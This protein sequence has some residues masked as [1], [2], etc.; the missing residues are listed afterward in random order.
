MTAPVD[1]RFTAVPS[2]RFRARFGPLG[3]EAAHSEM[4]LCIVAT[5]AVLLA[6]LLYALSLR[7]DCYFVKYGTVPRDGMYLGR[8]MLATNDAVSELCQE[9]KGHPRLMVSLQDDAWFGRFRAE[10]VAESDCGIWEDWVEHE[11]EVAAVVEAAFG[12][13]DEAQ[14]IAAV[15]ATRDDT[16]S[17]VA[18]IPPAQSGQRW[19]I[20][21]HVM[22]SPVT[23]DGNRELMGLGLAPLAVAPEYQ[24]R[25]FG[26]KLVSAALR[27]ARLF[28]HPFVVVLGDPGYYGRFGFVAAERLGLRYP[29]AEAAPHFMALELRAGGLDGVAGTVHYHS[30]FAE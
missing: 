29:V 13:P 12:R 9:L 5:D 8:C 7:A 14:M 18:Q 22:L 2:G 19:P 30:A 23:I 1:T 20:V 25:G 24:R 6:D 16:I 4:K 27:R 21:G 17:L 28:G 3:R 15:R 11:A 26:T 10:P